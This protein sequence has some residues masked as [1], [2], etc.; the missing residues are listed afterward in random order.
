MRNAISLNKSK[1]A[2]LGSTGLVRGRIL[3]L[4]VTKFFNSR[5]TSFRAKAALTRRA[6]RRFAHTAAAEQPA[7]FG[8]RARQRRFFAGVRHLF[9]AQDA[10][11]YFPL[12]LLRSVL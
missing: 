5:E 11:C 4:C 1:S 3:L 8:L 10:P 2:F 9:T 7:G 6:P 12:F